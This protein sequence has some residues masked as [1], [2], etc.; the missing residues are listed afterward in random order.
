MLALASARAASVKVE[1]KVEKPEDG[2]Y[3][4]PDLA[5]ALAS[6]FLPETVPAETE[7]AVEKLE[8]G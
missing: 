5:S 1:T 4:R 3:E 7:A 8:D 2:L 6:L